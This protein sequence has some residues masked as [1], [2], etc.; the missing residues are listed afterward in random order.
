MPII[1]ITDNGRASF[2]SLGTLRKGGPRQG[3]APGK[4]LETF[5][6]TSERPEVA[7]AFVS[8]YGEYP[9][10]LHVYLPYATVDENLDAWRE[11]W[12]AGGLVHRCDGQTMVRW[13]TPE[14]YYSSEPRPC[15]Y[16]S[17]EAERTAERP[18]CKPVGR[19]SLILP[20]LVQAG[21][22]GYVTLITTSI[23]DI[24]SLTA[25]LKDAARMRG[26]TEDGLRG[27]EWVLW[28]QREMISTPAG[29]GKRARRPKWLVKIAPASAWVQRQLELAKA[30]AM[31]QLP[32]PAPRL[33][34]GEVDEET[35]EI[36]APPDESDE[37]GEEPIQDGE[38]QQEAEGESAP[39]EAA[40]G[41][42]SHV[43]DLIA[44]REGQTN[45]NGKPW[46][47]EPAT[48]AQRQALAMLLKQALGAQTEQERYAVYEYL[49]GKADSGDMNMAE[50]GALLAW[51]AE[52]DEGGRLML[53]EGAAEEAQLVYRAAIRKQ[54]QQEMF[55]S[56]GAA[57]I[58]SFQEV[59]EIPF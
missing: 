53:K 42:K 41:I 44:E 50:C 37:E 33:A 18:G 58:P 26:H 27:I 6:F 57:A 38:F 17:G 48:Q 43:L 19:L 54:G 36:L 23:H 28:R 34:V 7:E 52:K 25:S 15:P 31:G 5:R 24:A 59:K 56:E 30:S 22:V 29:Q 16:C 11:E 32:E 40:G 2:P 9:S 45:K 12:V 13:R 21:Y 39:S 35:G 1:G 14:G 46:S 3:N 8:A 55:P 47:K 10:R 49:T 20:E 4:D 51:L